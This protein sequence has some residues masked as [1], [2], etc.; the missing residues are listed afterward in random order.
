MNTN[1][2]LSNIEERL[3]ILEKKYITVLDLSG[4][5]DGEI[6][7]IEEE[8]TNSV[9]EY[10]KNKYLGFMILQPSK[11]YIKRLNKPTSEDSD[12]YDEITELDGVII[13]S[14]DPNDILNNNL[15]I[16]IDE[17][18]KLNKL[19][20]NELRKHLK[21]INDK[22]KLDQQIVIKNVMTPNILQ[23]V[24]SLKRSK[25]HFQSQLDK[26]KTIAKLSSSPNEKYTRI[27]VIVETKHKVVKEEIEKKLKQIKE[28]KNFI[29]NAKL[30]YEVYNP[31]EQYRT[32]VKRLNKQLRRG[33]LNTKQF[34]A[35]KIELLNNPKYK[36]NI[37]KQLYDRIDDY[38]WNDK[39]IKTCDYENFN[40]DD[41]F[42]YMGGPLWEDE[43]LKELLLSNNHGIITQSMNRYTVSDRLQ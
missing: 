41:V 27:F 33:T 28:I 5:I 31:V 1:T 40:F 25:E 32:Q 37:E 4:Y 24:Q 43:N 16:Y 35:K 15:N 13:L 11:S 6:K 17:N 29:D 30:Y 18:K 23:N 14:N 10:L 36:E 20:E 9:I 22:L 7:L 12:N 19:Y 26:L 3:S 8:G 34:N 38:K 39:F 42:L 2:R 21:E